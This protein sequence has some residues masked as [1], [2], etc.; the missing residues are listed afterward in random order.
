LAR[1]SKIDDAKLSAR[2]FEFGAFPFIP[3]IGLAVYCNFVAYWAF[4][5]SEK[6]RARDCEP[7]RSEKLGSIAI[8]SASPKFPSGF[9]SSGT[10]R[11]SLHVYQR[12]TS[13]TSQSQT[14]RIE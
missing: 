6:A 12:R 2:G 7:Q 14:G 3:G 13:A 8:G 1:S 5:R 11:G 9:L 10:P 4:R